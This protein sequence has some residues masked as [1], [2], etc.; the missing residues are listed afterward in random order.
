MAQLIIEESLLPEPAQ[1]SI[2]RAVHERLSDIVA[3]LMGTP[4]VENGFYAGGDYIYPAAALEDWRRRLIDYLIRNRSFDEARLLIET[5][6]QEVAE[7]DLALESSSND[8]ED[9]TQRYQWVPLAAATIEL[10]AGSDM[11]KAMAELRDYCGLEGAAEMGDEGHGHRTP[12]TVLEG[13]RAVDGGREGD[14][15]GRAAL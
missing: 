4:A 12:R 10:R 5:I 3:G 11:T 8:S 14:R 2:Y 13:I 1:A 6:R 7:A 9:H 15:G